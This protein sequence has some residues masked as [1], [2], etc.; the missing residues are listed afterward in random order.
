MKGPAG[1]KPTKSGLG[2]HRITG[3]A[4]TGKLCR[5]CG[6]QHEMTGDK[7]PAYGQQCLKCQ[8]WDYFAVKCTKKTSGINR[9]ASGA[10]SVQYSNNDSDLDGTVMGEVAA[11]TSLHKAR[12][13]IP[14]QG[15]QIPSRQ[16]RLSLSA[17]YAS[18]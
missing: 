6:R 16:R 18:C 4:S 15:Y 3:R 17:I 9:V 2:S 5:F 12:M 8:G 14:G 1:P 7:C 11:V 13:R 10:A